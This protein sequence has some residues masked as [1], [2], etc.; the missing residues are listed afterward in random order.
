MS[1][2]SIKLSDFF[3][4]KAT[5]EGGQDTPPNGEQTTTDGGTADQDG[6]A[7]SDQADA[8]QAADD[9]AADD[10]TTDAPDTTDGGDAQVIEMTATEFNQMKADAS[11]YNTV[12]TELT[13]LRA[14]KASMDKLGT[15][16]GK[17]GDQNTRGA[18]NGATLADQ[19][20]NQAA[21]QAA[22]KAS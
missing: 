8:D 7:D 5:T 12:K 16:T 11:T 15:G 6:D 1:K 22:D 4:K 21:M 14:W 13:T 19:P 18:K 9:K 3:R 17:G 20:W 10:T 2:V